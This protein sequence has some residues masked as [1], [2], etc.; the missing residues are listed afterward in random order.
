VGTRQLTTEV[1]TQSKSS[2]L[3]APNFVNIGYLEKMQEACLLSILILT[4]HT[5]CSSFPKRIYECEHP[6]LS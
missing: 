2:K 4:E 3:L 6:L 5:I 1:E